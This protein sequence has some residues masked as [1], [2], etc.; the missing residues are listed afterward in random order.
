MKDCVN[1][2]GGQP[3][4]NVVHIGAHEGQEGQSY[5]ENGVESIIWIEASRR[6]MSRLFDKT[7]ALNVK[8]KYINACLSN[9]SNEIV[10][11]NIA[12]N[13]QSSSILKLGTHSKLHPQ[14][15]YIDKEILTTQR[16]DRLA[17]DQKID[18]EKIDFINLDVQGAELKVLKG[19]GNIL[20]S[21]NIRAIY[22]E[23]NFEY[24]YE[25]CCLAS[26]LDEYLAFYGF[27]RIITKGEVA[28]WGDALYKRIKSSSDSDE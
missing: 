6:F 16:F 1:L 11:F 28:Q 14:V 12:N 4:K 7:K 18:L 8:Q 22:T 5:V 2:T 3:F 27:K 24:V 15:S 26:E 19:F 10:E 23:I 13:E 21:N 9:L 25:D 20:C 17:I